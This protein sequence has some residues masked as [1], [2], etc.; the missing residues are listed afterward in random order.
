MSILV[1]VGINHSILGITQHKPAFYQISQLYLDFNI[2][3]KYK[4]VGLDA[5]I[6]IIITQTNA[7]CAIK[8]TLLW[9]DTA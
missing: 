8:D 9:I 3:T 2:S 5:T 1:W 6:A 4:T 7:L